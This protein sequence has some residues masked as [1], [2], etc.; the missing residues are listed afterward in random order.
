[1]DPVLAVIT[2]GLLLGLAGT[3]HC[4]CM[5]GGIASGALLML[6]PGSP[7]ARHVS[8]ALL[9]AG[10]I[11]TYAVAGGA[12][13]A[14]ASLTIDPSL[15]APSFRALQWVAAVAL[16][17]V[18]LS[19]AGMLPR[20]A[21]PGSATVALAGVVDPLITRLRRRAH[22][23]PYVLGIS[24]GLTPC[25]M[26]YAALV[27]AAIT[28]SFAGGVLWMAAFGIG[29]LPGVVSAVLGVSSLSR[30]RRGPAA[31]IA[32]GLAIAGLGFSSLYFGWPT[33]GALCLTR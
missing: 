24:W 4:A 17:W 32:A 10:R 13:S 3:V 1:M 14:M 5:C 19:T 8:L 2:G 23:G 22:L 26:V 29:T 12:V 15:T 6:D 16:M 18:G 20:L 27:S 33:A 25:P 31:E 21:L 7:R 11:T 30:I 9:Q 28:G